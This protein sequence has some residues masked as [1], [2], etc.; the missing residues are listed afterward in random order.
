MVVVGVALREPFSGW[1]NCPDVPL[2]KLSNGP[3]AVGNAKGL[4]W[5]RAQGFMNPAEIVMRDVQR[6]RRNVI[7][8]LLW[9]AIGK[10]SEP[11]LPHAKRKVLAFNVA[12]WNVLVGIARYYL[13]AYS[14]DGGGW[15]SPAPFITTGT[16]AGTN[17]FP[18]HRQPRTFWGMPTRVETPMEGFFREWARRT[19]PRVVGLAVDIAL[20]AT[21]A[22]LILGI[23]ELLLSPFF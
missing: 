19:D 9:E 7:I 18:P 10:A 14:Y 4:R 20:A 2:H 12:R 15:V 1:R 3:S 17:R 16:Y 13:F 23:G 5:R 8:K 11:A 6:D 21:T 22:R